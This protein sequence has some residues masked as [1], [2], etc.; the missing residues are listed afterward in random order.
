MIGLIDV[1]D[2]RKRR[3]FGA[4]QEPN[5]QRETASSHTSSFGLTSQTRQLDRKWLDSLYVLK[6]D[7]KPVRQVSAN[8]AA[9]RLRQ[10]RSKRFP[11]KGKGAVRLRS[12]TLA[13]M[14]MAAEQPV[15]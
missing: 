11:Q 7:D 14:C 13:S 10:R 8:L 15:S 1:I 5:V 4:E 3:G 9:S 12:S 2:Q 6:P